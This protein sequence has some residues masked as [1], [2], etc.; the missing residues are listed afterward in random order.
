M[1]RRDRIAKICTD[2]GVNA[3][4]GQ[5]MSHF[6]SLKVGGEIDAIAYPETRQQAAQ[7]VHALNEAG[8]RWSPLGYGT[9]LLVKDG[10]IQRVAVSLRTLEELLVFDETRVHVHAG[11]SLPRLVNAAADRGLAGIQGLAPI[12]GSVGGAI[13]MNAGSHGYEI[14]DVI[15]T[16]AVAR[17][18]EVVT[19]KRA[20]IAFAYRWSPFTETDLIL[21]TTLQLKHGDVAALKE[22]IKQYKQHRSATQPVRDSSAGCIFKNPGQGLT[23]GRIIDELGLKGKAEGGATISTLHANF[24]VTNGAATASEVFTL[25]DEIRSR[26]ATERG[27][28]LEL[29]VEVWE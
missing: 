17:A 29:E 5:K 20:E 25:I 13:K 19:L 21:G 10:E 6:T 14:A 15:E 4:I 23:T 28:D 24:I 27:I 26:V 22:E 3:R 7:L 16:V 18:G 8:I 2:L 1:E 11:Y 12:P 9:N